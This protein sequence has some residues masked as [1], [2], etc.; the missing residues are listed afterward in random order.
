M[1]PLTL[2][3]HTVHQFPLGQTSLLQHPIFLHNCLDL[4]PQRWMC[5]GYAA[6]SYTTLVNRFDV[7]WIEATESLSWARIISNGR[8]AATSSHQ[9]SESGCL[10]G[11]VPGSL[12]SRISSLLWTSPWTIRL[13]YWIC[14][15]ILRDQGRNQCTAGRGIGGHSRSIRAAINA[16]MLKLT[17]TLSHSSSRQISS[18]RNTRDDIWATIYGD[19]LAN[20][21][22]NLRLVREHSQYVHRGIIPLDSENVLFN[23]V[24]ASSERGMV[25]WPKSNSQITLHLKTILV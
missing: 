15:R 25:C 14:F 11:F 13:E 20:K 17:D 10:P 23:T 21:T 9:S 3:Q 7:V 1:Q 6:K 8:R 16:S 19:F 2:F 22:G 4:I 12:P 5:S 18:P 24:D